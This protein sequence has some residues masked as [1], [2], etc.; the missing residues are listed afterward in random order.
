LL[1]DIDCTG[2][3]FFDCCAAHR[4]LERTPA[5]WQ[6]LRYELSNFVQKQCIRSQHWHGAFI[7]AGEGRINAKRPSVRAIRAVRVGHRRLMPLRSAHGKAATSGS[8]GAAPSGISPGGLLTLAVAVA[9]KPESDDLPDAVICVKPESDDLLDAVIRG[10]PSSIVTQNIEDVQASADAPPAAS[11]EAPTWEETS[12]ALAWAAGYD[13]K[14]DDITEV[15]LSTWLQDLAPETVSAMIAGYRARKGCTAASTGR[16]PRKALG[17]PRRSYKT[18]S[19]SYRLWVGRKVAEWLQSEEGRLSQCRGKHWRDVAVMA[20]G[21][22]GSK[23]I[24][25]TIRHFFQRSCQLALKSDAA[26][27]MTAGRPFASATTRGGVLAWKNR[28]RASGNQ[29]RPFKTPELYPVLYEWFVNMRLSVRGRL[30]PRDLLAVASV[31]LQRTVEAT[32]AAGFVPDPPKLT[33]AWLRRFLDHYRISWK[34]PNKRYKVPYKVALSRARIYLMNCYAVRY[35]FIKLLGV[36]PDWEMYDQKPAMHNVS[37]SKNYGTLELPGRQDIPLL[38][39]HADT[40]AR[41]TLM[42][43][44]FSSLARAKR[45]IPLDLTFKLETN[46]CLPELAASSPDPSRYTFQASPSGSH[47]LEHV[48]TF[49]D[50][51]LLPLTHERLQNND[52]RIL[53]LDSLTVHLMQDVKEK[54]WSCYYAQVVCPG[55]LTGVFAGP[56]THCNAWVDRQIVLCQ[57]IRL[58]EKLRIRP[59]AVPTL[60]R[61]ELADIFTSVWGRKC[62]REG[63]TSFKENGQTLALNGSEDWKLK[64]SAKSF[65][66]EADMPKWR[67]VVLAKVDAYF[68]T[69]D[70]SQIKP[71]QWEEL[72]LDYDSDPAAQ[73]I[74]ALVE[75]QECDPPYDPNEGPCSED[76]DDE[77]EDLGDIREDEVWDPF[78]IPDAVPSPLGS[79]PS[80]DGNTVDIPENILAVMVGLCEKLKD[81]SL[82]T[83]LRS[84]QQR[85]ERVAAATVPA[86][87]AALAESTHL[88]NIATQR[89][90]VFA[91]WG[92]KAKNALKKLGQKTPTAAER[93]RKRIKLTPSLPD[94]TPLIPSLAPKAGE[95]L[96][97][98]AKKPS[99]VES[100]KLK[101]KQKLRKTVEKLK[102]K[103]KEQLKKKL[104]KT[105]KKTPGKEPAKVDGA[106]ALGAPAGNWT[107]INYTGV[108]SSRCATVNGPE[109]RFCNSCNFDGH[110]S[111]ACPKCKNT[112]RAWR[113]V[114]LKCEVRLVMSKE[115]EKVRTYAWGMSVCMYVYVC[116]YVRVGSSRCHP[117]LP[118]PSWFERRPS[119]LRSALC[120]ISDG[121]LFVRSDGQLCVRSFGCPSRC[122]DRGWNWKNGL[123]APPP[124][125]AGWMG[126]EAARGTFA[127][128]PGS[129]LAPTPPVNFGECS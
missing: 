111:I 68:A 20:F 31:L 57:N 78:A 124:P 95:V 33:G 72:V 114:C 62:H 102:A 86:V 74:G 118:P 52:I 43:G 110:K 67:K 5:T 18:T 75:G 12:L 24:P 69:Q 77:P 119:A 90:R 38:E 10:E 108:L 34:K 101:Y 70:P 98:D 63:E 92:D 7:Y 58:N 8:T 88:D 51:H 125:L 126:H 45:P 54:A 42:V 66:Y 61:L 6:A 15:L 17:A 49:L 113:T 105:A 41:S 22:D 40:R 3:C 82:L 29:G 21:H 46:R 89:E 115:K 96:A 128:A 84:R 60:S 71:Q 106:G 35:F 83:V 47:K 23:Q 104:K 87:S 127:D 11:A 107:C 39:N 36:D 56:D 91:K 9:G 27:A 26:G 59:A 120:A 16:A 129:E 44:T 32:V 55:G 73:G 112:Q 65:F 53:G 64:R 19:C 28:R 94:V 30:W 76:G 4:G 103:V 109:D 123:G 116:M 99:C 117:P 85:D 81:P 50:R 93:Q 37:G 48:L 13:G 1:P 25:K 100:V 97:N 121:Q 122:V 14:V 2:D 79:Q 80:L